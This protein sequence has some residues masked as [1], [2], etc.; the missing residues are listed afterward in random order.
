MVGK[1][2][3]E[4]KGK[5][6]A[7]TVI[8]PIHI[9]RHGYDF[10]IEA[11]SAIKGGVEVFARVFAKGKQIGFGKDGTVDIE[12]FRFFNPPNLV[13]DSKG[14]IIRV[15]PEGRVEKYKEDPAEA[16]YKMLADAV[17]LVGMGA[18]NIVRGKVGNTTSTFYATGDARMAYEN[19]ATFATAR[20]AA[21]ATFLGSM[22]YSGSEG[23][24]WTYVPSSNTNFG[25]GRLPLTFDTDALAG[26]SIV[27]AVLSIFT[28]TKIDDD[29]DGID[30]IAAVSFAPANAAA[31][32][33]GDWDSFGFTALSNTI[34]LGS[35]A[36]EGY[37]DLTLTADG[38]AIIN[39]AGNTTIGVIEGHDLENHAIVVVGGVNTNNRVYTYGLGTA[40][41]TKDEKLVVVHTTPPPNGFFMFMAPFN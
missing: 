8:G 10:E 39:K 1:H 12:R 3:Q 21:A 27:S 5:R 22:G 2:I 38:R 4:E 20:D 18:E 15:S 31:Y 14:D 26:E 13:P 41:T 33:T 36:T 34:D 23:N 9:R 28:A 24:P 17:S 29:N 16:L 6:I 7:A 40:G 35:I 32:A 25:I 37:N 11:I 30:Y 19:G